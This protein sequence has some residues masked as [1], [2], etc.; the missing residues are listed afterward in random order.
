MQEVVTMR[1][2]TVYTMYDRDVNLCGLMSCM[3]PFFLWIFSKKN[4]LSIIGIIGLVVLNV[5]ITLGLN[6]LA[7]L[8]YFLLKILIL[9]FVM[10]HLGLTGTATHMNTTC[11]LTC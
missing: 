1:E 4:K 9:S 10:N 7:L 8:G 2:S 5:I 6:K 3:Q 11:A